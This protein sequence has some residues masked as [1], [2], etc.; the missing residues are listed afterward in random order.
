MK[1]ALFSLIRTVV[2]TH[3]HTRTSPAALA[4]LSNAQLR[5]VSGGGNEVTSPKSVW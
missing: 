4:P 5:L 1:Q 3:S 2:R